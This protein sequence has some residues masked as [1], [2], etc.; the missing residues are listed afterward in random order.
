MVEVR[1]GLDDQLFCQIASRPF[2][3]IGIPPL[4][5]TH[6]R[7]VLSAR[8]ATYTKQVQR[9]A[10]FQAWNHRQHGTSHSQRTLQWRHA[11]L[12]F[13][14]LSQDKCQVHSRATF[15]PEFDARAQKVGGTQRDGLDIK[16]G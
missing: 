12:D 9:T 3:S 6:G 1:V 14:S 4:C 11:L 13:L 7:S 10:P 16:T 15:E 5:W 2:Q 8:L